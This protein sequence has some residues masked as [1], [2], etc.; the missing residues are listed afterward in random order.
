MSKEITTAVLLIK[1]HFAIDDSEL[2]LEQ[3]TSSELE[4]KLSKLISLLLHRDME[5]LLHAFYRIDLNEEK[6]KRI[7]SE[8]APENISTRLAQEVL[9]RELEK[10]ATREKYRS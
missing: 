3:Y 1:N 9:K 10:V 5:R 2:I 8:E 4:L 7:L 6:F